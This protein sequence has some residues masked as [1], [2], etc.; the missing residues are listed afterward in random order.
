MRIYSDTPHP[1]GGCEQRPR[2][3]RDAA[4]FLY[5]LALSQPR[6]WHC[7]LVKLSH[8]HVSQCEPAI[9]V[10]QIV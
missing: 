7:I 10:Y 4:Y 1:S 8:T 5:E 9:L 3:H 6:H 2:S